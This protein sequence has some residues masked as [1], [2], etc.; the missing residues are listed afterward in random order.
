[1]TRYF[2][3]FKFG[4]IEAI[5]IIVVMAVSFS[6]CGDTYLDKMWKSNVEHEEAIACDSERIAWLQAKCDTINRNIK[7]M[8][9]LVD[10]LYDNDYV[11]SVNQSET[12]YRIVFR[13]G[14]SVEIFNGKEGKDGN[15]GIDGTS[16]LDGE[17]GKDG[18]D[19]KNGI[20][21]EDASVPVISI[22]Q[23]EDNQW[24]WTLDGELI[25]DSEGKLIPVY[26][27]NAVIPQ[28]RLALGRWQISYDE[29][30]NWYDA[31]QA[32][33]MNGDTLFA[34]IYTT[35]TQVVFNF[36]DGTSFTFPRWNGLEISLDID[37]GETGVEPCKE[38]QINYQLNSL[39]SGE[40]LP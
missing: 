21:G 17:N 4:L 30:E 7:S 40:I 37:G 36:S 33:G 16:G 25:T 28:L 24:Y 34:E 39:L 18:E 8:R 3:K 13:K 32:D 26:G 35:D 14:G 9:T 2:N 10:A 20:D 29:G 27:E 1:M 15:D 19:G 11:I 38:I 23:A 5:F 12:G 6:G 22:K 31:G